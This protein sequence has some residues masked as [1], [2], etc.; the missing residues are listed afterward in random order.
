MTKKHSLSWNGGE[1]DIWTLGCKIIP[2]F[3]LNNRII[4]PLH[5]ANW[6]GESSDEFNALPGILKNLRGEFPCVPFG[7]NSPVENISEDW[8]D[9][10]SEAPYVVNE[11]HGFCANK[12]WELLEKT[13]TRTSI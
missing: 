3:K 9:S 4:V 13:G 10:Y 8:K 6:I 12:N 2:K 5:S 7:I 11:P 1:I